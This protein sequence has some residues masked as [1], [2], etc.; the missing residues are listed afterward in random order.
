MREG[1]NERTEETES[2]ENASSYAE[3]HRLRSGPFLLKGPIF[4]ALSR[5]RL[6]YIL[7][8][9]LEKHGLSVIS[10]FFIKGNDI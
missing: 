2:D 1:A 7:I 6:V 3:R 5:A 9:V 8:L 4:S 10:E